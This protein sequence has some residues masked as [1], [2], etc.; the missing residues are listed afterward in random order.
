MVFALAGDSTTTSFISAFVS[1]LW[2][3]ASHVREG[4]KAE[5]SASSRG[6]KKGCG[7]WRLDSQA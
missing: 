4:G 6:C 3:S 7:Q 2:K 1:I 5:G